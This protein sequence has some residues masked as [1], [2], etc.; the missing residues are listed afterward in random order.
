MR[1]FASLAVTI[2]GL[3]LLTTGCQTTKGFAPPTLAA[4][5]VRPNSGGSLYAYVSDNISRVYVYALPLTSSSQPLWDIATSATTGDIAFGESQVYVVLG[6]LPPY[7]HQGLLVYVPQKKGAISYLLSVPVN[8]VLTVDSAHDLFEGQTFRGSSFYAYQVNVF[9]API[10]RHSVPAF[11]MNTA[12]NQTGNLTRGLAFDTHGNFWVK[13]DDNGKMERYR[14]PFSSNSH[15][16]LA[17]VKQSGTP[18]GSVAFDGNDVMYVTDGN[19]IDVYKPPFSRKTTKAFTISVPA[20]PN[21]LSVDSS[22]DLYMAS[23]DGNVY[24]FAPPFTPSSTPQVTMPI[25][26]A[27]NTGN[28]TIKP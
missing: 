15:P 8:G 21:T 27:P 14:P 23:R 20:Q 16:D 22:G 17:F 13:D 19:G 26:G 4:S 3:A 25:P 11:T 9:K 12:V 5:A 24:V 2:V 6:G 1:S 28:I 7:Q 10:T 18:Y